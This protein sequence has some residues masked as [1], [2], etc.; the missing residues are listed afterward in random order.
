MKSKVHELI[1]E[2]KL[3]VPKKDTAK[4]SGLAVRISKDSD[5]FSWIM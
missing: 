5:W 2:K 1:F 3:L 4:I